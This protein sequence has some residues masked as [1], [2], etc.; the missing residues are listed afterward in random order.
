MDASSKA[1]F[2]FSFDLMKEM[3]KTEGDKNIFYSPLGISLVLKMAMLGT[4]GNTKTEIEKVLHVSEECPTQDCQ[5][6]P[7]SIKALLS[8]Q[9]GKKYD[10]KVVNAL[11]GEKTITFLEQYLQLIKK[12]FNVELNPAD[13]KNNAEI[14]RQ[15]INEWVK[16]LTNGK[17]TDLYAE[18]K[19]DGSTVLALVNAIYFKGQ[20]AIKFNPENT[21]EETFNVNK[22]EKKTIQMM[23]HSGKFKFAALP[24]I[25]SK[26]L[27]LPYQEDISMIIVL[28]DET[29]GIKELM[30]K[31]TPELLT[32]LAETKDLKET[33]IDVKIPKFKL[34]ADYELKSKL[35]EMGMKEVFQENADLSGMSNAKGFVLSSVAHKSCIDVNEEGT[36]AAAATGAGVSAT[37]AYVR[38]QFTVDHPFMFCLVNNKDMLMLFCGVVS[39]P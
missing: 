12:E 34:E 32:S 22:N 38:K 28:P 35:I 25:K 36:E 27:L 37:V 39:S 9:A 13:F 4:S 18:G 24:D 5:G 23:S 20:W 3:L 21:R 31:T 17:I 14:E 10:L 30:S 11:F 16:C 8:N 2:N 6:L 7:S 1:V 33:D 26:V 29:E 15:K 19:L